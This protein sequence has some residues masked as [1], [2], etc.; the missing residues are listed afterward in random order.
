MRIIKVNIICYLI[1]VFLVCIMAV[2]E[3][4]RAEEYLANVPA[5]A[6]NSP[7]APYRQTITPDFDSMRWVQ[8]TQKAW[9]DGD[10]RMPHW[11]YDCEGDQYGHFTTWASPTMWILEGMAY[12]RH[13]FTG[14]DML[15]AIN[16]AATHF[17]TCLW[18][19]ASL[20][21]GALFIAAIGWRGAFII[22][23][24]YSV[25]FASLYGI[26][27][28]DYHLLQILA[29]LAMILCLSAPFME[30]NNGRHARV[31]FVLAALFCAFSLWLCASTQ[32]QILVGVFIGFLFLPQKA[33]ERVDSSLWRLFGEISALFSAI[34]Y[35]VEYGTLFPLDMFVNNPVYSC[36]V[37]VFGIWMWQIHSFAGSGRRWNVLD[38]RALVYSALLLLVVALPFIAYMPECLTYTNATH[39]RWYEMVGE[40]QPVGIQTTVSSNLFLFTAFTIGIIGIIKRRQQQK[41]GEWMP[42]ALL[43]GCV[44]FF[45]YYGISCYRFIVFGLVCVTTLTCLALPLSRHESLGRIAGVFLLLNF[46]SSVHDSARMTTAA[47]V[48]GDISSVRGGIIMRHESEKLLLVDAKANGTFLSPPNDSAVLGF[49]SDLPAVCTDYWNFNVMQDTYSLFFSGTGDGKWT[50]VRAKLHQYHISYLVI[51]R[52]FDFS[53]SYMFFGRY[54]INPQRTFATY[55]LETPHDNFPSWL[56]L[57]SEDEY[58][59][60]IRVLQ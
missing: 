17:N 28:C 6:A 38:T 37:F 34:L 54:R 32:A 7:I 5:C 23:A 29:G 47:R 3:T 40:F 50:Y 22:P 15:S 26:F 56:R 60:I 59:R 4:K 20:I 2:Y 42:F 8:M 53:K 16:G 36:G 39:T 48:Y 49:Y 46:V 21:L 24:I 13:T 57:E 10:W 11:V 43:A 12:V 44:L 19:M 51:P 35:F 27:S 25:L 30:E 18:V 45:G 55:L 52:Q 31:W 41:T 33:A 9:S 1:G 58:F 14:E